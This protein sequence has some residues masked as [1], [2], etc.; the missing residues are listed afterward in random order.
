MD[1]LNYRP[2]SALITAIQ[3]GEV[4]AIDRAFECVYDELSRLAGAIR[5]NRAGAT[6]NTS[7]LVHEVYVKLQSQGSIAVQDRLHFMRIAA[8]AM[9][10]VLVD[11]IE[12]KNA[13]KRG[14]GA[15]G[16]TLNED[17][18]GKAVEV[19]HFLAVH[20]AISR[21]ECF[22]PKQAQ[23]VECRFFAGLSIPETAKLLNVSV[24]KVNREWQMARAWL[25]KE[26]RN[27]P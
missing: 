18:H 23:I 26:L 1:Q 8:R 20:D 6:L 5:R 19:E 12:R 27:S 16:I 14:G 21:L 3:R 17:L 4:G 13:K 25:A 15:A 22:D 9:R 10:Q 2:L 11:S 24:S 7:A